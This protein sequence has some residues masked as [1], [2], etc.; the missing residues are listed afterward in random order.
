MIRSPTGLVETE[1]PDLLISLDNIDMS[2]VM[3][4]NG[5][6]FNKNTNTILGTISKITGS[7]NLEKELNNK[8]K[9]FLA[10]ADNRE[11]IDI[12]RLF[13]HMCIGFSDYQM[14]KEFY[15]VQRKIVEIKQEW[16]KCF[17]GTFKWFEKFKHDA[18]I[19][20][21]AEL[22]GK[23]KYLYGL[24]SSNMAKKEIAL[25]NIVRWAIRY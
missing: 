8:G 2:R 25:Q 14:A 6:I 13:I 20:G 23:K 19:M 10:I 5:F 1:K 9:G 24:N 15:V 16:K 4:P 17:P 7:H 12:Y 11:D 22:H 21:Y 3:E 18:M